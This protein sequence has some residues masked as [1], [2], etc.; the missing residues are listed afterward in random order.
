MN[1]IYVIGPRDKAPADAKVINVTSR[2]KSPFSPFFHGTSEPI[3]ALR[4]ENAWQFSKVY[5]EHDYNGHPTKAWFKWRE[6]GL[7][8]TW[9]HRY[10][11]GKGATPLY[12]YYNGERLDYVEARK[13][14][15]IPLYRNMISNLPGVLDEVLEELTRQDIALWDFDGYNAPG[16][17]FE[18]IVE[19]PNKK[20]GHAF[21]LREIIKEEYA[22]RHPRSI[23]L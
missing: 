13:V 16:K 14:L 11:F 3:K 5:P 18:E 1:Q 6:E 21:V 12:S 7:A 9:A 23:N 15:Y 17:S 4:M 22:K 8:D 2:A 20:M 19:D 10:P